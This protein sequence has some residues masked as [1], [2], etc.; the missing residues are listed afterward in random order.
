MVLKDE[1]LDTIPNIIYFLF[2]LLVMS[3]S[4]VNIIE[5]GYIVKPIN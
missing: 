4:L 2:L 1:R 5:A 3:I